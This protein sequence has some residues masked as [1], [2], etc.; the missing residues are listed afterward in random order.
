MFPKIL[1]NILIAALS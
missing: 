1:G